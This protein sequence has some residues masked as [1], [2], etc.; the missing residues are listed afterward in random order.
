M[1]RR[2]VISIKKQVTIAGA[3]FEFNSFGT[4]INIVVSWAQVVL[5]RTLV[6][7]TRSRDF[8]RMYSTN[9]KKGRKCQT[10]SDR[11][12]DYMEANHVESPQELPDYLERNQRAWPGTELRAQG[13]QYRCSRYGSFECH[14]GKAQGNTDHLKIRNTVVKSYMPDNH[15]KRPCF[16]FV[17][18][19]SVIIRV[20]RCWVL[21]HAVFYFLSSKMKKL[22]SSHINSIYIT[23]AISFM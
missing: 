13:A 7:W 21:I 23:F 11:L 19:E 10:T 1:S 9:S 15:V 5:V 3:G 2:L 18:S 16:S 14:S 22:K 12:E 20:A 8:W 4:N 17:S 6:F